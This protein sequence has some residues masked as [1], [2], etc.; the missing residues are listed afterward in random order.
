MRGEFSGLEPENRR[1][2]EGDDKIADKASGDAA[3]RN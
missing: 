3:V 2:G 1:D